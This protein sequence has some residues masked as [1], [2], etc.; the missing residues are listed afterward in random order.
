M[1]GIFDPQIRKDLTIDTILRTISTFDMKN[2]NVNSVQPSLNQFHAFL[3][4]KLSDAAKETAAF[5]A[6]RSLFEAAEALYRTLNHHTVENLAIFTTSGRYLSVQQEHDLMAITAK[7][8]AAIQTESIQR[9]LKQDSTLS[10]DDRAALKS[11]LDFYGSI[12]QATC[13]ALGN[14]RWLE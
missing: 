8:V 2:Y 12:T 1:K 14:P 6:V 11:A 10:E 3:E 7:Y 4:G 13:A 5:W 9:T